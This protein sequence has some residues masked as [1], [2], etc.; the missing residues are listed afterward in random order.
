MDYVNDGKVCSSWKTLPLKK[1][2]PVIR[3]YRTN[4][5]KK[6]KNEICKET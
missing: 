2:I 4:S 3:H 6:K 1:Y 5:I